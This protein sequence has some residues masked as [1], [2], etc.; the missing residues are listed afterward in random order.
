MSKQDSSADPMGPGYDLKEASGTE[1]HVADDSSSTSSGISA[2]KT[3][4]TAGLEEYHIPIDSYEGR[5]RY[6]PTFRW[7]EE[8][9]TKLVRKVTS[10]Q[11]FLLLA[12]LW[13]NNSIPDRFAYMHLGV[14]YFLR[15]TV[16]GQ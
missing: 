13:L 9:E 7:V 12:W 2:Q 8:E 16:S 10:S 11:P 4:L 3:F 14:P 5:H 1:T 15:S 6:D